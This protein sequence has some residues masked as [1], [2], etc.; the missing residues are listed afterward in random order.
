[1]LAD[2]EEASDRTVERLAEMPAVVRP[3]TSLAAAL[4][5][6]VHSDPSGVPVASEGRVLVGWLTH[7]TV[8][9]ALA[10]PSTVAVRPQPVAQPTASAL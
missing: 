7:Q 6:L 1:V 9:R 4:D 5:V 10:T 3:D 8:L 2:D